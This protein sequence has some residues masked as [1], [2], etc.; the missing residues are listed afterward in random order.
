MLWI[1][2]AIWMCRKRCILSVAERRLQNPRTWACR[3]LTEVEGGGD[4]E[5]GVVADVM[6]LG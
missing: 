6:V 4:H 2:S 5:D 1:Q 3:G